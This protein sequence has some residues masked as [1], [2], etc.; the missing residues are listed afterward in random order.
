MVARMGFLYAK[1]KELA[2]G[3]S[4]ESENFC[5]CCFAHVVNLTAG[6]CMIGAYAKIVKIRHLVAPLNTL[7]QRRGL[8][9]KD[10]RELK[11]NCEL[12]NLDCKT[13]W[14]LIL[15]LVE[16]GSKEGK[17]LNDLV[18]RT[19]ALADLRVTEVELSTAENI[20]TFLFFIAAHTVQK[21]AKATSHLECR[22]SFLKIFQKIAE[23]L[24]LAAMAPFRQLQ[25]ACSKT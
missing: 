22:L 8:L 15:L 5:V 14:S 7:V 20:F 3:R 16:R 25:A 13:R 19:D 1:C 23:G 12:P 11:F 21:M 6:Y 17:I 9:D 2:I 4:V 18:G 24:L 10:R